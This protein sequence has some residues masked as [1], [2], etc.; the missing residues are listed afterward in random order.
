M[1]DL[2]TFKDGAF[3]IS[4]WMYPACVTKKTPDQNMKTCAIKNMSQY[5]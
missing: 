2:P 4:V 5:I 3:P 1:A